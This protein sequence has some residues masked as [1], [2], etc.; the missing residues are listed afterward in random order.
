MKITPLSNVNF[1][2]VY[3]VSAT[4]EQMDELYNATFD[5]RRNEKLI[6][7]DATDIY[8]VAKGDD[9]CVN[10]VKEGK[11]V[12][13]FITGKNV[14]DVMFMKN[15]WNSVIGIAK[16][17]FETYKIGDVKEAISYF[18]NKTKKDWQEDFPNK[19]YF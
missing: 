5:E 2:K 4:S 15:G 11:E 8:K 12:A 16:H 7:Q 18:K 3:A 19:E 14:D 13:F 10:S 1:S 6:I 9:F 17:I